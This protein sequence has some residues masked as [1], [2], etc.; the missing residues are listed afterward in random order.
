MAPAGFRLLVDSVLPVVWSSCCSSDAAG[1]WN[2][3]DDSFESGESQVN[4]VVELYP[5]DG[6]GGA[7]NDADDI[8]GWPAVS[9]S[10]LSVRL[11]M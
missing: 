7:R 1:F 2:S 3:G 4:D 8:R 5:C 11:V 6:P 9:D 10:A